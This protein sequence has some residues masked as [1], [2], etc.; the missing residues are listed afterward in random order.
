MTRPILVLA[1]LLALTG[2]ACVGL[3][4][5]KKCAEGTGDAELDID[6]CTRGI[7]SG[8]LSKRDLGATFNNRGNAYADKGEYGLA[9]ADFDQAIRLKPD[10]ALALANKGMAL[11]DKARILATACNAD[12]GDGD[13]AV[14]LAQQ[15][16]RLLDDPRT[17]DT[18]AAAYA[19]AGRFDEA[20]AEQRRVIEIIRT[21]DWSQDRL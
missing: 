21:T 19:E 7:D 18:L 2:T 4:D 9:I 1:V 5:A 14:R 8:N 13:E 20:V 16:V 15:A 17:R 11:N 10:Y 12:R 6:Y 3:D